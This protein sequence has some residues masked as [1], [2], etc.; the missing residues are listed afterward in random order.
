M[1]AN[2][3]M[4]LCLDR[5]AKGRQNSLANYATG[6][7][8][9]AKVDAAADETYEN[10]VKGVDMTAVDAALAAG[11][12]WS[13]SALRAFFTLHD[14]YVRDLGYAAANG[15]PALAAYLAAVGGWRVPYLATESAFEAQ[16][17]RLPAA[18]VFPKGTLVANEADPSSSGMHLFGTLTGPSTWAAVDG[19]LPTTVGP[20][21]ILAVGMA[22]TQT[23]GATFRC[24]N[25]VAATTKDIALSLSTAAQYTQTVLG[26]TTVAAGAAAGATSVQVA[27]TTN[28]TAGEYAL[29]W[30]SDALQEVI[31]LGAHGTGPTRLTV[32]GSGTLKNTYTTAAV[33]YPL[34]RSAAYQ[35]SGSGTEAVNVYA[36]PDRA[37]AL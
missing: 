19:A 7:D 6:D 8:F 11:T 23:V 13:T 28:F 26:Q 5:I 34:F 37:I 4:K 10:V 12:S 31:L 18:Q 35:G 33:V 21:A 36:M 14:T 20:C 15:A 9:W 2:S 32:A 3:A 24:T 29:I 1:S 25:Y 30:E 16:N 22:A 27:A 17:L